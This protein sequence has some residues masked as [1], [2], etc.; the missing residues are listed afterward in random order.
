M[1]LV[2]K[3]SQQGSSHEVSVS[4]EGVEELKRIDQMTALQ[5]HC[6]GVEIQEPRGLLAEHPR[7]SKV[8]EAITIRSGDST[9]SGGS[10]HHTS[11]NRLVVHDTVNN[12]RHKSSSYIRKHYK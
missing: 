2:L 10:C 4:T 9:V 11:G 6:S 12:I 1:E 5:P 8:S 7:R 3:Q